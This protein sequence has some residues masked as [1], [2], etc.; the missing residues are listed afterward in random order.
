MEKRQHPRILVPLVVEL[1]HATLGTKLA[2]AK[3]LSDG[4]VFV[5]LVDHALQDG[6]NLQIRL[7]TELVGDT[8]NAPTV[9]TQVVRVD[10]DGIALTFK[11]RTAHHLWSSV[12]RLRDELLIG[13]DFFQAY[14]AIVGCHPEMG[15]LLVQQHGKWGFP[16]Y[17]LEVDVE[18]QEARRKYMG[19]QFGAIDFADQG[20]MEVRTFYNQILPEA[21]TLCVMHAVAIQNTRLKLAASS[22]YKDLR[23][24]VRP[25]DIND[26]TVAHTWVR[27]V[28]LAQLERMTQT[29]T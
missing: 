20:P 9:Q 7:K 4:G 17:Y 29:T 27:S 3:D 24:V 2:T 10:D 26:L 15:I 13:R 19:E 25:K 1:S 8:Q 23:W 14:E 16:G 5:Y 21:S 6:A 18:P 28:A 11:N 22:S 12:E